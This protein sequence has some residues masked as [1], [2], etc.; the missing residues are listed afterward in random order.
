MGISSNKQSYDEDSN[1]KINNKET[2]SKKKEDKHQPFKTW[3]L[4]FLAFKNGLALTWVIINNISIY[5]PNAVGQF[6]ENS[7]SH[8][9]LRFCTICNFSVFKH[10]INFVAGQFLKKLHTTDSLQNNYP[11]FLINIMRIIT[12]IV[13]RLSQ[14]NK[15][16]KDIAKEGLTPSFF[17]LRVGYNVISWWA[18]WISVSQPCSTNDRYT[19]I[20]IYSDFFVITPRC[21][22]NLWSFDITRNIIMNQAISCT[23]VI[24]RANFTSRI[25]R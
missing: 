6:T 18:R 21:W 5:L 17:V 24:R 4:L 20:F 13:I 19:I 2:V 11:S 14:K 1:N 25:A 10:L 22:P 8:Q 3:I 16:S 7:H 12:T 15:K 23:I 9:N